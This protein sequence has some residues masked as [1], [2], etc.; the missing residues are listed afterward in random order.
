[1]ATIKIV[2]TD[3]VAQQLHQQALKENR[4][5]SAMGLILLREGFEQRRAATS[6]VSEVS[7]LVEVLRAPS[8][9]PTH[10]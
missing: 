10:D 3:L 2:A 1:M 7:Q 4:T 6:Q 8:A 5:L 9:E